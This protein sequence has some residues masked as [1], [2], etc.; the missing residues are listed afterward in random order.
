MDEAWAVLERLRRIELLER[1]GASP[2]HLLA[3]VRALLAEAESWVRA[4]GPGTDP[5][6]AALERCREALAAGAP[7]EPIRA[8]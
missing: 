2:Q 8:A 1:E 3:E 6:A 4:E 5:A 7:R